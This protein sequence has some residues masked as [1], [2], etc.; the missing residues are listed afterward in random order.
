MA[1]AKGL[2][3]AAAIAV[4]ADED[5]PAF[6]NNPMV[7]E[8]VRYD[9]FISYASPDIVAAEDL[10]QRLAGRRVFFARKTI[11]PGAEFDLELA[12][13]LNASAT[14]VILIS[15]RSGEAFYERAEIARAIGRYR[16]DKTCVRLVPV[17]LNGIAAMDLPFVGLELVQGLDAATLGMEGVAAAL[18]TDPGSPIEAATHPEIEGPARP[19]HSV[20]LIR[21]VPPGGV[22]GADLIRREL[23]EA[24]ALAIP[25]TQAALAVVEAN[26][27]LVEAAPDEVDVGVIRHIDL[28]D[29]A[30]VPPFT[31]WIAAF[32][33]ARLHGPR[34]IAALLL[35]LPDD[36]YSTSARTQRDRLIH[37][38]RRSPS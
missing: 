13:A 30:T 9:F 5:H 12:S 35:S 27:L 4:V 22:V 32:N 21:G 33:Q 10:C 28:P 17:Y 14:I 23:I 29:P 6:P 7:G 19:S 25:N 18:L 31:F 1:P 16:A 8:D 3:T 20:A 15:H 2:T 34:M 38:L 24:F 26:A 37:I 36:R 11:A